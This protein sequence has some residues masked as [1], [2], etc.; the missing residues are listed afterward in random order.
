MPKLTINGLTLTVLITVVVSMHCPKKDQ[1]RAQGCFQPGLGGEPLPAQAVG[2]AAPKC[3]E[4]PRSKITRKLLTNE[5]AG[6]GG[7]PLPAQA[8]RL[9]APKRAEMPRK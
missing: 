8:V 9:A 7:E 1:L 6:L 2:F 4:M 5:N 3:A